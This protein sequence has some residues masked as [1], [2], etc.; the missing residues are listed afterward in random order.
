[1]FDD[2]HAPTLPALSS[3]TCFS[4]R[5][6][7]GTEAGGGEDSLTSA[8]QSRVAELMASALPTIIPYIPS[9]SQARA[10]AVLKPR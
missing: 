5:N 1:M 9:L 8:A 6:E 10:A 3:K 4:M 7:K 2:E